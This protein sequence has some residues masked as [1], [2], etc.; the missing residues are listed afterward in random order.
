MEDITQVT[1]ESTFI[2][3]RDRENEFL[4]ACFYA[5]IIL[6]DLCNSTK[7]KQRMTFPAWVLVMQDFFETI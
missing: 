7:I 5:Y 1:I 3:R 4:D 2:D 6:I